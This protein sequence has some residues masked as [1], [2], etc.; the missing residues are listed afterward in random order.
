MSTSWIATSA[1]A[2]APR[3]AC[4]PARVAVTAASASLTNSMRLAPASV[5][6]SRT[7]PSPTSRSSLAVMCS[8]SSPGT[9]AVGARH[10]SP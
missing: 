10:Q 6:A 7:T 2:L 8:A 9:S 3:A 4:E 1:G 5:S